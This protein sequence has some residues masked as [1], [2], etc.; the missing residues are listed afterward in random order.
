MADLLRFHAS[1]MNNNSDE[2]G[3]HLLATL[4]TLTVIAVT[5]MVIL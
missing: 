5:I 2:A 4:G 3:L 1:A